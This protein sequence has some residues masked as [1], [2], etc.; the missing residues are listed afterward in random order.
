MLTNRNLLPVV[1]TRSTWYHT[2]TI[3]FL[4]SFA[5]SIPKK[6]L[7]IADKLGIESLLIRPWLVTD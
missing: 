4:Q 2:M 1:A 3:Y 5:T 6:V 7:K